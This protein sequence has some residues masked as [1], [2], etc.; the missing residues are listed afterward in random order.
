MVAGGLAPRVDEF[1]VMVSFGPKIVAFA[2]S[3]VA[4]AASGLIWVVDQ[5]R[6][7]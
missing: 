3:V 5:P 6:K 7:P 2:M 1:A 4:F